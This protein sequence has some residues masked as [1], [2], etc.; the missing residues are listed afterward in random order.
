MSRIAL[1]LG[2]ASVLACVAM[3]VFAV[4]S[5]VL[6]GSELLP[7]RPGIADFFAIMAIVLAFPIVGLVIAWKRPTNPVGWLFL[8]TG[9]M[10]ALDIFSSEYSGRVAFAGASLPGGALLA[11]TESMWILGPLVALPLA[12]T[13]FPDGRLPASRWRLAL[14]VA[15]TLSVIATAIAALAPGNLLGYEG[16]FVNPFAAPGEIGRLAAWMAEVGT[17]TQLLPPLVGIAAIGVRFRR[18]RGAERQQLKWLL[19]PLA[20]F[21]T[22]ITTGIAVAS[23]QPTLANDVRWMF[24]VALVALALVPISA[25]IAVLRYRLY[26]IDLVIRRTLVYGAVVVILGVSYIAL[27]LGLQS[28][29]TTFSGNDTVP[30]ALSTL[31]IAAMFVPLRT[32]V[33]QVVDRRFYRSRYDA[34]RTVESFAG[35]LRDEVE[36]DA[37]RQALANTVGEAVRPASIGVWLRARGGS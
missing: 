10:M 16:R 29:L 26:D 31:I 6:P 2:V 4:V 14:T 33:R 13:V 8:V 24:T 22:M 34:Q 25:G 27:V 1:P 17:V 32:R 3:T 35:R 12:L 18:A 23:T 7:N 36:L 37:V 15:V 5:L 30:V 9:L 19:F 28:A 21:V 20:L 11:W